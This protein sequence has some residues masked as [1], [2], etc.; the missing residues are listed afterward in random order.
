MEDSVDFTISEDRRLQCL[1][2][3]KLLVTNL[4]EHID[5]AETFENLAIFPPNKK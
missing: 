1:P 5:S 3:W 2:V 4:T